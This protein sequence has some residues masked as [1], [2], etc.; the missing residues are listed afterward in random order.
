MPRKAQFSKEDIVAIALDVVAKRGIDALTAKTLGAALGTSTSP[1]FTLFDS[2]GQVQ[3]DVRCA[4]MERFETYADKV[5]H[6]T[7]A[8]KQAGMQ[9]IRFALDEPHLYQ[10]CFMTG[11]SQLTHFREIYDL[12]GE[13][14]PKCIAVIRKDYGLTEQEAEALFEHVWIYTYGIGALCATGMCHFSEEE[15]S[16]MLTRDFTGMMLFIRSQREKEGQ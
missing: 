12:L 4:A 5:K 16:D 10:L 13:S 6:I 9:M 14:A 7:P 15:I 1:I 3:A 2:M 8:F 11:D